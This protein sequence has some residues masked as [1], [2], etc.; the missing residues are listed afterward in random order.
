MNLSKAG[1]HLICWDWEDE[2]DTLAAYRHYVQIWICFTTMAP[3]DF[4][5][6]TD[7]TNTTSITLQAHFLA[8]EALLKP[9]L[10]VEFG[11]R[12]IV[13]RNGLMALRSCASLSALG[14]SSH[15]ILWPLR[16]LGRNAKAFK[17]ST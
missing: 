4:A 2:S 7:D 1:Q 3:S 16:I 13:Q 17:N 8:I 5:M 9:W 6:F 12:E 11:D 14:P 10:I 15:L